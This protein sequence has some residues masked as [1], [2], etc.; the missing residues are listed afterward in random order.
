M[1][2]RFPRAVTNNVGSRPLPRGNQGYVTPHDMNVSPTP[3]VG[4]VGERVVNLSPEDHKEERPVQSGRFYFVLCLFNSYVW[5]YN[6]G[7]FN[8]SNLQFLGYGA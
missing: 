5:L 2:H 1:L 7:N 6:I 3:G 8:R 4:E